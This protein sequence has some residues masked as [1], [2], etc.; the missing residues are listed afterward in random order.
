MTRVTRWPDAP[1]RR[2][3]DDA[4]ELFDGRE[5][6]EDL[7]EPVVPERAHT[8]ARGRGFDLVPRSLLRG[9]VLELVVH[10]QELEDADPA[11]IARLGAPGATLLLVELRAVE[12]HRDLGTGPKP[13]QL[14]GRDLVRLRAVLAE[15]A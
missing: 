12:G 2:L 3:D 11:A 14:L 13:D 4:G 15:P 1:R 8:A 6:G 7:V 5:P 9:Q 10:A